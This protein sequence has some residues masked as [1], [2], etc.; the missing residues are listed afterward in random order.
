MVYS[1][2]HEIILID[3]IVHKIQSKHIV[4]MIC[5]SASILDFTIIYYVDVKHILIVHS[6]QV[7]AIV[8]YQPVACAAD[9]N[10]H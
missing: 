7:P 2:V 10:L 1:I 6:S 8:I 3:Q 4:Q 5:I 9:K